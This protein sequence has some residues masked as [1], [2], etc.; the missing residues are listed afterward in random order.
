M[1]HILKYLAL[2]ILISPLAVNAEESR[3]D[4]AKD[5]IVALDMDSQFK[6]MAE[7]TRE[8]Q[9]RQLSQINVPE[10]AKPLID[11]YLNDV[12]DLVFSIL[13]EPEVKEQFA[14]LYAETFTTEQ[15]KEIIAFYST[16]A[17][18]IFLQEFPQIMARI[19]KIT[20]AQLADAHPK[21]L[22]MQRELKSDL[23]ELR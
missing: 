17:G 13:K 1:N 21:M 2:L 7:S 20:E 22:E 23:A 18:K 16:G 14:Q 9:A 6:A 15:L 8:M 3:I 5:L 10:E 11:K 4:L 12:S 19:S